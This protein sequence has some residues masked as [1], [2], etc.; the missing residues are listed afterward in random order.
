MASLDEEGDVGS[1]SLTAQLRKVWY[2]VVITWVCKV[3]MSPMLLSIIIIVRE[4]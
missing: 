1:N 2:G 3:R 4:Y